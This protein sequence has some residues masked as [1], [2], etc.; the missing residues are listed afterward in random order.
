MTRSRYDGGLVGA[1]LP[2]G[3]FG[4]IDAAIEVASCFG[5]GFS[6]CRRSLHAQTKRLGLT[7]ERR[8]ENG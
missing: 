2:A 8:F 1:K 6:L 3:N 4:R 5:S 7:R